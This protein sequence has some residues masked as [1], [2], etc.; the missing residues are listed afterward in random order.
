MKTIFYTISFMAL[1][2]SPVS[3]VM[4]EMNY[5]NQQSTNKDGDTE[6][7]ND[8]ATGGGTDINTNVTIN[9]TN[10]AIIDP[11]LMPSKP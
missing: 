8:N 3:C 10:V 6:N 5:Y 2:G 4:E 7:E 9:T 11:P 1:L